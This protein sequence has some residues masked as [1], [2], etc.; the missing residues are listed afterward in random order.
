MGRARAV[1]RPGQPPTEVGGCGRGLSRLRFLLL[2]AIA[3]CS[4]QA[5][6]P[7]AD[8]GAPRT[9]DAS[10]FP[11]PPD[12]SVLDASDASQA[13]EDA[14]SPPA[15]DASDRF[16]SQVISFTQ[17][18][19]AGFNADDVLAT[20][21]GPPQGYGAVAGSLDV[22]SLGGGGEI[23]VG[24]GDNAIVD[25]PGVD[26]IVFENP[27]NDGSG[28]YVEPGEVAVSEDGVTWTAYP[29][30]DTTQNE[31]DGGWGA[32]RCGGMNIVYANALTNSISPFDPAT[33][34]GDAFDLH[35]IGVTRA[36]FVRIRNIVASEWC[37]EAG[38]VPDGDTLPTKNGFDLD[39]ISIVNA[40]LP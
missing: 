13:P 26:F 31:P 39:A 20:V 8:T 6:S 23:I 37:P 12:G 32:T 35:E 22:V 29:C 36:K 21:S 16:V 19:C 15:R 4:S 38:W 30:T 33:A 2:M 9:H 11:P 5:A 25:G 40:E 10:F 3:A 17:G 18:T 34:G 14:G 28:R 7:S 24:F 27:F 1:P